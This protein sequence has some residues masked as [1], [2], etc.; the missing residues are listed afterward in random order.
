MEVKG[1]MIRFVRPFLSDRSIKVRVGNTLS[2]PFKLEEGVPQDSVPSVTSFAVAINSVISEISCPV[3]ASLFVDNLAIYCT[4]YDAES[5]CRYIQ[6]SINSISE[7]AKHNGFK[8]STNK[9]VAIRLTRCKCQEAVPHLKLGAILPYA[10]EVKFLGMTFYSKLTWVKHIDDLKLKVKKSLNL[11]K[12]ISGF[13]W[14]ADKKSL[15]R[16]YDAL[17]RSKLD[18]GCQIYS[19]TSKSN[20]DAFNVVHNMGLR[21]CCGPFRTSPVESLYVGTHQLPPD[22]RREELSLCYLMRIKCTPDNPSN[23]VI[24]QVNASKSRPRSSTPLQVRLD[25]FVTDLPLETQS[26]LEVIPSRDWL[27]PKAKLCQKAIVKKNTSDQMIKAIFLEHDE[28]HGGEYKIYTD[29]SKTRVGVGFA[30]AAD[31]SWD[32][33]KLSSCASIYTAELTAVINAMNMAYHANQ[34]SFVI[35]SDSKS[36]LE[37]LNNYNSSHPLFRRIKSGC[38][39]S[40]VGINLWPFVG[41]LLM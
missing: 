19:S 17:C 21:I 33:A 26:I 40:P 34:K 39:G 5:V 7:C 29:G 41:F 22:L 24:C 8:F 27:I 1:N 2:P 35:F 20:L 9:T 31:D 4:A 37:S 12:V 36:S 13:D 38:F 3:R 25:Q 16:I 10:D 11:L 6:K 32:F 30:V 23:K 15:L 18:Y 14:G 28:V